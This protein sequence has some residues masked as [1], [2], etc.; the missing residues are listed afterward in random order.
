MLRP[1]KKL[2][3]K[4]KT[5]IYIKKATRHQEIENKKALPQSLKST[6]FQI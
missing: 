5:I 6:H 4:R 2:E 1:L 3:K